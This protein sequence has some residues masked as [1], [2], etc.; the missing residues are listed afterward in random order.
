MRLNSVGALFG[1]AFVAAFTA[2][3]IADRAGY[4]IERP[5]VV[6]R[7]LV[8]CVAA[9][10][11]VGSTVP[12]WGSRV[13]LDRVP[14]WLRSYVRTSGSTRCGPPLRARSLRSC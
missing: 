3:L 13:G 2:F 10:F 5:E 1:L 7:F 8:F 6:F 9:L 12:A 4:T 14:R 11:A